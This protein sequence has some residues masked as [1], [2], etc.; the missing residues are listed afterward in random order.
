MSKSIQLVITDLD[1]TLLNS[2]GEVSAANEQA[3]RQCLAQG[4]PVTIATGK[5]RHSALKIINKLNLPTPGVFIQGLIICAA[6]GTVLAQQQ[7]GMDIVE[8]V[9]PFVQEHG[10]D[11]FAYC[12]E[13][14]LTLQDSALRYKLNGRYAEP[15]ADIVPNLADWAEMGVC[16]L[17][18]QQDAPAFSASLRQQL[19][20]L[21]GERATLTQALT[22]SVE[23]L[24]HGAS[25]GAGVA[26]LLHYLN[27][28]PH[29]VL[30][31]GDAENDVEMLQ[32]VGTGVAMGNAVPRLKAVADYVVGSN[33]DDGVAEA[34]G[35]FALQP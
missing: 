21:I 14:L 2:H 13:R 1:G 20:D 30:A 15:L 32:L 26:Q 16:K 28:D 6:D 3:L 7:L 9:V 31:I 35:R 29:H 4:I 22:N 24:P 19:R 33:D 18:V 34:I 25:K 17:L 23:I 11:V 8:Q 12:H 5:T 27:V 10:V